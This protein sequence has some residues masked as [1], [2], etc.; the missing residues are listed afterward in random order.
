MP[1]K[2]T[3]MKRNPYILDDDTPVVG[4]LCQLDF[5]FTKTPKLKGLVL[6]PIP[7]DNQGSV[8]FSIDDA[9]GEEVVIYLDG[10]S[11]DPKGDAKFV[12]REGGTE[13]ITV[14]SRWS[15]IIE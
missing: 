11:I 5:V 3:F 2:L 6:D 1:W 10:N 15:I 12:Y 4:S 14:E 13:T 9:E 8:E 7:T